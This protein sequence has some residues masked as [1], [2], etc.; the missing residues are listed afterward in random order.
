M[1]FTAHNKEARAVWDS[2]YAGA[3]IRMPVMLGLNPRYYLLDPALNKDNISFRRYTED[4]ITMAKVQLAFN[5]YRC[6]NLYADDQMGLPDVWNIYAD[7]QNVG[8]GVYFGGE[9]WYPDG[10]TPAVKP[11]LTE[12]NRDAFISDKLPDPFGGVLGMARDH[13][14]KMREYAETHTYLDRPIN[15]NWCS[16]I[17]TDGPMTAAC[18][19]M[20]TAEFCMSLY[21]D[22]GYAQKLLAFITEGII[23]RIKEWKKF[24]GYAETSKG[25]SF[26]DDSIALISTDAYEELIM[27]HHVRIIEA[28]SDDLS[29]TNSIH[30]CGDATRHFKLLRDKLNVY[31]FD[32][33]FPV[34]HGELVKELGPDVTVS[35][36]PHIDLLLHGTP[37]QVAAETKRIIDEVKPHT[38]RFIM[39]DGNN[40]APKTPAENIRAMYETVREYGQY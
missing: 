39:R 30:L 28:M 38:K 6:Q 16:A 32:T 37:D 9:L 1:D 12:D 15:V 21:D 20:G 14:A 34:K 17:S 10:S 7:L 4:A 11:F 22:D 33:G 35:G 25:C 3:P 23:Y 24:F 27:P 31:N 19:I 29:A 2:F 40:I 36:G 26:A 18:D 5:E 13:V 8:D